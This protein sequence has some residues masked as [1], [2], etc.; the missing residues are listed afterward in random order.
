MCEKQAEKG[1]EADGEREA[2]GGQEST[3]HEHDLELTLW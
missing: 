2:G 1:C 3:S